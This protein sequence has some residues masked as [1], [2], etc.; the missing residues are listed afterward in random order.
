MAYQKQLYAS[1][2]CW[3]KDPECTIRHSDYDDDD[4]PTL[5]G[6]AV[7]AWYS[8]G[9]LHRL[10]GPA[11]IYPNGDRRYFIRGREFHDVRHWTVAV[12]KEERKP[13]LSYEL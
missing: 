8:E 11:V 12:N 2:V 4:H 1:S 9:L 13:A 5:E 3:F 7:K 10:N 6:E